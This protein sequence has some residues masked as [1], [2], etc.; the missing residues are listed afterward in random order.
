V[1]R[2]WHGFPFMYR[3]VRKEINVLSSVKIKLSA[4]MSNVP[5]ASQSSNGI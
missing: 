5:A 2:L 4:V 1:R 3:V